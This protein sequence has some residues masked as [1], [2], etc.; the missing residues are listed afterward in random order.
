LPGLDY[1]IYFFAD[2]VYPT[3]AAH[4]LFGDFA[5]TRMRARW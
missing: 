2:Q 3:P 1:N 4:R 5:Y